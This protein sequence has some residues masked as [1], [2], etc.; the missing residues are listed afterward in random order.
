MSHP[1][2]SHATQTQA[3]EPKIFENNQSFWAINEEWDA[4]HQEASQYATRLSHSLKRIRKD[5]N[6][7]PKQFHNKRIYKRTM[8]DLTQITAL[9]DF[10]EKIQENILHKTY[11]W[12]QDFHVLCKSYLMPILYDI[13][14]KKFLLNTKSL[15]TFMDT[16]LKL[17]QIL[18][19]EP[20]TQKEFLHSKISNAP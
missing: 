18:E 2:L 4:D 8:K 10:I 1:L 14:T 11:D 3:N 12:E 19:A 6:Q 17:S 20:N 7:Y 13:Q 9:I 16:I 15:Q 5:I